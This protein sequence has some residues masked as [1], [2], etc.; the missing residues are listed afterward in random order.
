MVSFVLR[1]VRTMD[2][3]GTFDIFISGEKIDRIVPSGSVASE[4][5]GFDGGGSIALP[6]FIDSHVHL[7]KAFLIYGSEYQKNT[8]ERYRVTRELK[9]TF[10][11]IQLDK[12]IFI[13]GKE[14]QEIISKKARINK[15]IKSAFTKDN[16]KERASRGIQMAVSNGTGR[17]RTSAD[18]D[19]MVG[20]LCL[21]ALL[22]LK[23]ESGQLVDLQVVAFAQEGLFRHDN[24]IELLRKAME[25]GADLLGGHTGMDANPADHIN[26][27]LALAKEHNVD[28]EF[29]VDESGKPGDFWVVRLA[30]SV[31]EAGYEGRVSAI[32][33]CSLAAIENSK[34]KDAIKMIKDAGMN[35]VVGPQIIGPTRKITRVAELMEAGVNVALGSDN[36]RGTW[37]PL[38]N[39]NLMLSCYL[40]TAVNRLFSGQAFEE[41]HNL[42]TYNGA[43][44]LKVSDYGLAE[45][46]MADIVVLQG[47]SFW[48][49]LLVQ[50]PVK[51]VLKR[52]KLLNV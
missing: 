8:A 21:E 39:A 36:L 52:G 33:C 47:E 4:V 35:V 32:H 34:A 13:E 23:K 6:S 18:I 19:P 40:L 49:A 51:A 24:S 30:R 38:G 17:M 25:L 7:D 50:R 42:I 44:V 12:A 15:E 16:V 27:M 11:H 31:M 10:S 46:R 43:R 22:E 9:S 45:G 29:H 1:N 5:P 48:D 28:V 20:I 37:Y 14:D 26:T 2:K 41:L 3:A